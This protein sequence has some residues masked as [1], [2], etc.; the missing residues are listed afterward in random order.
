[1]DDQ[2]T[3]GKGLAEHA[4]LP[5]KLADLIASM[6]D[7]LEAHLAALDVTDARSL[8]ERDAYLDL[9]RENREAAVQLKA[10]ATQMAGYRDLP[11][12]RH[13]E[14]AMAGPRVLHSF[15]RFVRSEQELLA[16][17]QHRVEEDKEMLA[18]MGAA[19]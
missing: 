8:A 1:M 18:V 10:I 12:G 7:V 3:C 5:A 19:R 14:E 4:V 2:P 6:A 9:V 17:L 11:M 15:Q 13:I 16:L